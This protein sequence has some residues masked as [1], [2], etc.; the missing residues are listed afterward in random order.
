MIR[1]FVAQAQPASPVA[2]DLE[3]ICEQGISRLRRMASDTQDSLERLASGSR[4]PLA[5]TPRR[6]GRAPLQHFTNPMLT[7]RCAATFTPWPPTAQLMQ[8]LYMLF[9]SL[10]DAIIAKTPNTA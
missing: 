8:K 3:R 10:Y 4:D 9:Y 2:G 7:T 5:R 6:Q 1:C